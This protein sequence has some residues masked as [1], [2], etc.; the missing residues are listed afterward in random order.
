M[1]GSYIKKQSYP[2]K[3]EMAI[4]CDVYYNALIVHLLM[5]SVVSKYFT[6]LNRIP[7]NN[8][9]LQNRRCL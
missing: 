1:V 4:C 9:N 3:K 5:T 6:P 8:T 2:L 7:L